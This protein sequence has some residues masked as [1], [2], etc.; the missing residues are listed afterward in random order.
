MIGNDPLVNGTNLS[1]RLRR[2]FSV[3]DADRL[4]ATARRAYRE[5]NPGASVEEARE[6]VSCAADALFV[7]LEH[8]GI[9]G[10]A[11]D[12]RLAGYA[13]DGLTVG[14]WRAQVV[15]NEPG[16]LSAEPRRDCLRGD[17]FALP[18]DEFD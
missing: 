1:L 7:L 13:A 5:L 8:A 12:G 3:A 4:L 6:M 11:V 2:D 9:L 16:P 14:G 15:L 18:P 10:D 17:V